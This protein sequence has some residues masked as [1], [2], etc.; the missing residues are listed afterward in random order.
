MKKIA[1]GFILVV[2]CIFLFV[3]CQNETIQDMNFENIANAT[4]IEINHDY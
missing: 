2:L 4:K 1:D 3:G